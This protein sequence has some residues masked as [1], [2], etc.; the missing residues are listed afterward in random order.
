MTDCPDSDTS[1]KLFKILSNKQGEKNYIQKLYFRK[2]SHEIRKA[3]GIDI[4]T[5][6][7]R[8][9]YKRRIL[10]TKKGSLLRGW[11]PTYCRSPKPKIAEKQNRKCHPNCTEMVSKKL[12]EEQHW[13]NLYI[14][15][16]EKE[17]N[18]RKHYRN[19]KRKTSKNNAKEII[20]NIKHLNR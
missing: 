15:F 3:S 12:H 17:E 9:L 1:R 19:R 5:H 2:R 14:D 10:K 16:K 18:K 20:K 4:T 13:Q 6:F 11:Y 7:T 8:P